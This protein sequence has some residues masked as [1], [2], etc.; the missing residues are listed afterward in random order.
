MEMKINKKI[1][2]KKEINNNSNNKKLIMIFKWKIFKLNVHFVKII[3]NR[4]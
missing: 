3:G 4:V 1:K 2:I